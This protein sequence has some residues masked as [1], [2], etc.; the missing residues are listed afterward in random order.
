M[1]K[2]LQDLKREYETCHELGFE[3]V[4]RDR[5]LEEVERKLNALGEEI[6]KEEIAYFL[7]GP[8]AKRPA[9][10]SVYAGAGG[11]DAEDWASILFEMYQK[12]ARSRGWDVTLL[13]RHEGEGNRGLKNASME[14]KGKYAFGYLHREAGVHR[15]VRVSP[16]SAKNLRH[17]SFAYVEVIPEIESVREVNINPEDIELETFRSSGPGGQNVNKRSTAVRLIHKPTGVIVA[18][19]TER[20]QAQ[21]RALAEKMLASRLLEMKQRQHAKEINDIR[22]EKVSI[23]WGSQIRSYV[24]HP[25]QLVKDHRTGVETTNVRAVLDGGLDVFIEAEIKLD[26]SSKEV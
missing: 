14:I 19:Q 4:E 2:R 18:V 5:L 24:F 10:L 15:L 1:E 12:Y 8:Y 23:E 13:H 17:T 16:F 21:N 20:S 9:M 7:S 6:H 22:G 26:D 25:Y 11:Q 3:D